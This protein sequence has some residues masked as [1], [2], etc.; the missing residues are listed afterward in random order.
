MIFLRVL[1]ER[2]VHFSVENRMKPI[3]KAIFLAGISLMALFPFAL[4][5]AR[6][7]PAPVVKVIQGR[8]DVP[9]GFCSLAQKGDILIFDGKNIA[10]LGATPRQIIT[11]A[12]YPYGQAMGSLIGFAPGETGAAAG[13]LNIGA[14]VLRVGDKTHHLGYS[15]LDRVKDT[16]G[17]TT[18][19]FEAAGTYQDKEGRQAEIRSLYVFDPEKGWLEISST[20][21][22]T[23]TVAFEN[24]SFSLFFDAYDRFNFSPHDEKR[25]PRLNYRVY[26][27]KGYFLGWLSFNP[28]E[29]GESRFPGCL[30][31][32]ESANLRYI[33]L[34]DRSGERLMSRIYDTI[35]V[36]PLKASVSFKDFDGTWLELSVREVL[37]SSVFFRA[38]LVNPALQQ[39]LLPAG[40]YRV[41]ANFFPGSAEELLEVRPD[42]ENT[43]SL[44]N[45]PTGKVGVKIQDSRGEFVP[46]KVTFFGLG[47]TKTPYFRPDN[48]VETGRSWEGFK[49][50]C[51]PT[52]GGLDVELPVGTYLASASRGPEYSIDEKAVEIVKEENH[53]LVFVINRVVDTPGLIALDPHI[54]TTESDA[55]VSVAE[56]IRSVV[57]EGIEVLV[58][59]DHNSITDYGPALKKLNL[60]GKLA[61]IPGS[62][63][64]VPDVIH[65]NTYPMEIRPGELGHGAINALGDE[66]GPLFQASRRKNPGAVVQV[67]HPRAGDLGYFNNFDLDQTSAATA[68]AP[69]DMSF[70]VLEVLNGPYFYSS[71]ETSIEDWF[72]L[73]NRGYLFPIVGSSDSHG[74]DRDEPGY[75]RTYVHYPK[76][77]PV[78][79][80]MGSL[81]Q[82]I[83]KGR[84]FA[85]NGP[86]IDFRVNGDFG[87]G[88]LCPAAGGKV[89]IH[90]EVKS[91]PW[92]SVD[93]VR[94]VLN[95]ERRIVF[96]VHSGE[97]EVKKFEQQ[98]SLTL[99]RDT[100]LCVEALGKRTLFPVIQRPT[101]N[102]S[103][104]GGTLPYAITN[105]VFVDVDGNK[106]FDP[107]V[108][109]KIR[110]VAE[111][112]EPRKKIPRL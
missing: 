59:T 95:G 75:S 72:H 109:E 49:N 7:V 104:K 65:Y 22:N 108:P 47:A 105:P 80:D 112:A 31:P 86:I 38:I 42:G 70:D 35:G 20:L 88:D 8:Q 99:G 10:V 17:T 90:I 44:R 77:A 102:G 25:F 74:I 106:K 73:L 21:T 68:L 64:T 96:P 28:V 23:G 11:S 60:D 48:P 111:T 3:G 39:I 101:R 94:L 110:Q 30:A 84:S 92:V 5:A 40:I 50:S 41:Q 87:P 61:V 33:L 71:N 15:R 32:G 89:D 45:P 4:A 91:A 53:D 107:L 93:E 19:G 82:S 13:D 12:N 57:A 103:L 56:R 54:H 43:C 51:F 34:A 14:P 83:K 16:A 9:D 69:L 24:S 81:L 6:E 2:Y 26:Q 27:K 1:E 55:S 52:A 66:A 76:E 78:P 98:I 37:S 58:A 63:V 36:A 100:Y 79:L 67:N 18:L 46:G 62:E 29:K 97:A 85:T